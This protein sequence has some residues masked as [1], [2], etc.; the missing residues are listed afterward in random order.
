MF[1]KDKIETFNYF[2]SMFN[3]SNMSLSDLK[4]ALTKLVDAKAKLNKERVVL[5]GGHYGLNTDKIKSEL[6]DGLDNIILDVKNLTDEY[7]YY[8]DDGDMSNGQ[9][10]NHIG[11]AEVDETM[12]VK[13]TDGGV[14]KEYDYI[15]IE[16]CKHCNVKLSCGY[17]D[18]EWFHCQG[19][20]NVYDGH[21]QCTCDMI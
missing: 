16:K 8:D 3:Q 17:D 20:H 9:H 15:E 12:E 4:D 10:N 11:T 1:K 6:L 21:A 19:C 18:N 2:L 5:I 14:Q 13:E 7:D